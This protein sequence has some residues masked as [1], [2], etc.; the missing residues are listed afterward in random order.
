[1]G[2]GLRDSYELWQAARAEFDAERP[3]EGGTYAARA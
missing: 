2:L 1:M 3:Q